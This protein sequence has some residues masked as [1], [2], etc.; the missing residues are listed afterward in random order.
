V[1]VEG[2]SGNV[3]NFDY[4]DED[5]E[6][7]SGPESDPDVDDGGDITE[8]SPLSSPNLSPFLPRRKSVPASLHHHRSKLRADS[9]S[10][11]E[12]DAAV[13]VSLSSLFIHY[14]FVYIDLYL[15]NLLYI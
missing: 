11:E 4:S 9:E 6:A 3:P 14:S 1:P 12:F 5:F 8:V 13:P 10:D 2:A 7:S 15:Q